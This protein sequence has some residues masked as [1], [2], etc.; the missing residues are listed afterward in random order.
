MGSWRAAPFRADTSYR[1]EK[2]AHCRELLDMAQSE[3]VHDEA[4]EDYR[5][6][7]MKKSP[8]FPYLSVRFVASAA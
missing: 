6:P 5:H 2:L 4:D 7:G 8:A 1:E 3:P